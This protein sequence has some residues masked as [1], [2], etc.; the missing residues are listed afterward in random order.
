VLSR[1]GSSLPGLGVLY[2]LANAKGEA[3]EMSRSGSR[4]SC[5]LL[6]QPRCRL[7]P[8]R[9]PNRL[10]ERDPSNSMLLSTHCQGKRA[11]GETRRIQILFTTLFK[12][13]TVRPGVRRP[14]RR[15]H[16]INTPR[17]N[18]PICLWWSSVVPDSA[19]VQQVPYLEFPRLRSRRSGRYPPALSL[20][21]TNLLRTYLRWY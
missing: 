17:S 18:Y 8:E 19:H 3:C 14:A 13:S 15:G 6:L 1:G 20:S 9:L 2:P 10:R 4:G 16:A 5:I 11:S 7:S 12:T 21:E